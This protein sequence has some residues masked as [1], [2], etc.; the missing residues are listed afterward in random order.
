VPGVADRPPRP[1]SSNSKAGAPTQH[2]PR[3]TPPPQPP[4]PPPH[5]IR[6]LLAAGH[7]DRV[8]HLMGRPYRL[9]A[10]V[11]FGPQDA[12]AADHRNGTGT[13]SCSSSGT[14][15]GNRSG[16]D[17]EDDG[18]DRP[19]PLVVSTSSMD[20]HE[21]EAVP[22]Q[23]R[24][25]G[26]MALV[27]HDGLLNAAPGAGRYAAALNL[28][29]GATPADELLHLEAAAAAAAP[30]PSRRISAPRL[31]VEVGREGL[32]LPAEP[33]LHAMAGAGGLAG[34]HALVVLDFESRLR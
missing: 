18:R 17:D 16:A 6:E 10:A 27:T 31:E 15:S 4:T 11:A 34:G 7:V 19:R 25:G 28:Y 8:V 26:R 20:G 23:L 14:S 22:V 32:L 3:H 30:A 24:N 12:A 21:S 9:A 33:L 2:P 13:G 1:T 5:Q 29:V